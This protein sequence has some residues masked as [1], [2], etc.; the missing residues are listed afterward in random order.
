M[1]NHDKQL[2][3]DIKNALYMHGKLS[4]LFY[5]TLDEWIVHKWGESDR[6]SVI[7]QNLF[8]KY[9]R[10]GMEDEANTLT[11]MDLPNDVDIIFQL[12]TCGTLKKT[13]NEIGFL[14]E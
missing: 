14:T 12:I 11:L 9:R 1:D 10:A 3:E 6:L 8:E 5:R 2:K 7:H 13:L 4:L